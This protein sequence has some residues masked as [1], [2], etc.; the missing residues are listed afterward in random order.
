[1]AFNLSTASNTTISLYD[2]NGHVV[3]QNKLANVTVENTSLSTSNLASGLYLLK[4]DM[5][6]KDTKTFKLIKP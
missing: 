6:N 1:V 3:Y 4:I 5:Q 2:V